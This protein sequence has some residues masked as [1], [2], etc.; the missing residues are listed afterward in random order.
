MQYTQYGRTGLKA[1]RFG[2]GC[3]RFPPDEREAVSTVRYAI[4]HGVNYLDTAYVY[5]DSEATTGKALKGG[6]REKIYL[7]TKSP[8]WNIE[9][10]EDFE[11][12]LDE[13]LLRLGTDYIDVYLLH[14]L[15]PGNWE[16]VKKYDGLKFLDRMIEKGKIRHKA[17][18]IHSTTAAFREIVDA[19][20]WE[21]CQLQLNILDA[22]NQ[23]GVE[24]LH[25]A[26]E[27]G[28]ATVIME[29]LRGGYLINNTPREV[30][31][32][33]DAYP[34]KRPLVEWCFRWLYNMPE[35]SVILSGTSS[36]EQLKDN[37]RIFESAES[38]CMSAGDQA[39]IVKIR[40]TF[41]AKRSIGCTGCRYCMPCP[42][43]VS[44]PEIF[45]LYNNYQLLGS[46]P[47]DK[48]VYQRSY[49]SEGQGA[50]QCA[51]CGACMRHCP[52]SLKIPELLGQVHAELSK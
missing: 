33:I 47:I 30:A 23:V 52:Q 18:S 36:L 21:M 12:Y 17:F 40:E 43:N 46:H 44:I 26:A 5:K 38:G 1:S 28:L 48:F 49:V 25:Y 31:E 8:I 10:Y 24:G 27:K 9:K 51:S 6:Y 41:E 15:F 35:V 34:D 32:L 11:K 45:K 42:K 13:Q 3:M 37:L 19:F 29:P 2:L 22:Y 39:L 20:S 50:D 4:D 16:K 7:A 14:N